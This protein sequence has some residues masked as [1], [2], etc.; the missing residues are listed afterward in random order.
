MESLEEVDSVAVVLAMAEVK[1]LGDVAPAGV[2]Q[3]RGGWCWSAIL[4][5]TKHVDWEGPG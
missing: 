3:A 4:Q 1:P 2:V 5:T